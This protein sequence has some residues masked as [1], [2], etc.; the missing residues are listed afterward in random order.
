MLEM[1]CTFW[2]VGQGLFSSGS[3][4]NNN[5]EKFN[6]VYDCGAVKSAR[7]Y[8]NHSISKMRSEL[9]DNE[10]IDLLVISHFDEDHISGLGDLLLGKKVKRLVIPYF[11]LWKRLILADMAN[12]PFN[13]PLFRFYL[14]P[15]EYILENF[16]DSFSEEGQILLLPETEEVHFP[17]NPDR[18]ERIEFQDLNEKAIH[19]NKVKLLSKGYGYLHHNAIEFIFYNAPL[20]ELKKYPSDFKQYKDEIEKITQL[21]QYGK[22][23]TDQL[24][25]ICDKYFVRTNKK[26]KQ[27][28]HDRNIIS[29]FLYIGYIEHC[30]KSYQFKQ[31]QR[32]SLYE[33]RKLEG[34]GSP[35]HYA[36]NQSIYEI[37]LP[38]PEVKHSRNG[39]L[40]TGDGSLKNQKQFEHLHLAL[41]DKRMRNIFCFQ[42][43]HHGSRNNWQKGLADKIQPCI[44][45]FSADPNYA[46]YRHPHAEVVKDF[47]P[48]SP[49]LV[50]QNSYITFNIL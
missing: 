43:L 45:V 21:Q 6:W 31:I 40:Y 36:G 34:I 7:Q 44:S 35:I 8:L 41:G 27:N 15:I 16:S 14:N 18:R 29:T 1:K 42:V 12:I 19:H 10:P 2:A 38:S 26:G 28:S 37:L 3:I 4:S 22:A 49:I 33:S 32:V 17:L 5:S 46:N 39:I 24:K 47:L 48:Y 13:S 9:K 30:D 50:N 11:P 25:A 23:E 20:S